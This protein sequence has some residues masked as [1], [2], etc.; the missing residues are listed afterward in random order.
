VKKI[1]FL[2][3][4]CLLLVALVIPACKGGPAT[5][6]KVIKVGVFGPMQYLQ[7]KHNWWGA[8]MAADEINSAG[9]VKIGSDVYQ[10][11]LIQTDTNEINSITDATAAMEK[12]I[13]V[14]KADFLM[15]GF[16]TEAVL[17]MQEVAMDNH[18][19]FMICGAAD[20]V[21]VASVKTNYDRYKYTFR[22][23]PFVSAKLADNVVMEVAMAGAIIK[24][25]TGIQRPLKVAVCTE[26]AKWADSI[27]QI[28]NNFVPRKLGME[29]VGTW[30]P[31]PTATELTA[32]MTAMQAAKTDIICEIFSGPV[33]IPYGKSYGE[34]KIP[35]ASVGIN[36]ES[37]GCPDY[38]TNTNGLGQYDT[39]LNSYAQNMECTPLE[40]PFVDKFMSLHDN[41][42]PAY[43]AGTYDAMY[44]LKS[45]LERAGTAAVKAD[46]TFDSDVM[47][48]SLEQTNQLTTLATPF[49]FTPV[50]TPGGNPHDVTY[51]PGIDTGIATQW[52]DGK[53]VGVWPNPA[54][55]DA[56]VAAGYDPAWKNVNY[57]G[58]VKWTVP[59]LLS[60]K[61]KAEAATQPAAPPPSEQPAAPPPAGEQPAA[62]ATSYPAKTYTNDKYGFSIQLPKD[63]VSNPSLVVT[64]YHID[65]IGVSNFIPGVAMLVFPADAPESKDWILKT[66]A[67]QKATDTKLQGDIKDDTV[68]GH[69]AYTYKVKY[70]SSTGYEI[71][72]YVMDVDAGTNRIRF[73]VYTIDQFS[74]YDEKLF[75]EIAHT[76]TF[77]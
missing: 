65:V 15:G 9:G 35:A 76:V 31:S 56:Y 55:G 7:G 2:L 13:T 40:K 11:K 24:E 63:W 10:I 34:L 37:E 29:V 44:I 49:S 47:V 58:I 54:Y 64:P 77:K 21:L 51:G 41:E 8:Q 62:G 75:S 69:K 32:E 74:P 45:A 48:T 42:V 71:D 23:T 57:P 30:R 46:G 38:W 19:I 43:N 5:T 16:R 50:D 25:E 36:V 1:L 61:L 14:D 22:C 66:F 68:S 27:T 60:D 52:V 6:G 4:T 20:Q 53:M 33:G 59:P 28:M 3:F 17:P 70:I 12:L 26:G 73:D 67:D 72:A 18:K 39:T